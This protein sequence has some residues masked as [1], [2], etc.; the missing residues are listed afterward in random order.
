ME[1]KVGTARIAY[2]GKH[3]TI[4]RSLITVAD[5]ISDLWTLLNCG[6]YDLIR[7]VIFGDEKQYQPWS[8][9]Y[10][11]RGVFETNREAAN[12]KDLKGIVLPTRSML[13]GL[14]AV[15]KTTD[16]LRTP[17][18]DYLGMVNEELDAIT[19]MQKGVHHTFSG[20]DNFGF[21][22]GEVR[23]RDFGGKGVPEFLKEHR[24]NMRRL[25]MMLAESELSIRRK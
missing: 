4:K 19:L 9:S 20:I 11:I 14:L 21:D 7:T 10:S 3:T 1:S 17:F 25:L 2:I 13:G 18:Y 23:L 6:R 12:W 5:S 22:Q 15:Q 8:L 16:D 24:E